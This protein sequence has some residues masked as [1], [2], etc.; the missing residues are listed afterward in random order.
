ID[1]VKGTTPEPPSMFAAYEPS[2]PT[3]ARVTVRGNAY[4][5]G[6]EVPRGFLHIAT[7]GRPPPIP[8]QTGGRLQ[9]VEWLTDPKNPLTARVAVNRFWHHLFGAGLVRSV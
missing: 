2:S 9:L 5:L 1:H 8:S 7:V 6:A 3:N 4:Q